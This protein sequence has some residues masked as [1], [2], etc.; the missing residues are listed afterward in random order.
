MNGGTG[1]LI[2]VE[3]M[4]SNFIAFLNNS[5]IEFL[6]QG[7]YGMAFRATLIPEA[8]SP[9]K[10]L[11]VEQY[12]APV[13]SI[14]IKLSV[15]GYKNSLNLMGYDLISP[16]EIDEFANEVNIQ[17]DIFLKTMETM[18]PLCPAIVFSKAFEG[19]TTILDSLVSKQ[20]RLQDLKMI[21]KY[22]T[23]YTII[24]MELMESYVTA[25]KYIQEYN[26][27]GQELLV[28]MTAFI[29]IE[30][31]LR[32]GYT[33]ADFHNQN[34]MINPSD[35]TMFSGL[36][37]S[38]ILIDFGLARKLSQKEMTRL[39]E[40]TKKN[41]FENAMNWICKYPSS[42]GSMPNEYYPICFLKDKSRR[43]SN[44]GDVTIT[45]AT[46][47]YINNLRI[48]QL[49]EQYEEQTDNRVQRFNATH[50][51][52]MLLP[53]SNAMK[54]RMYPGIEINEKMNEN[55]SD[56]EQKINEPRKY[57]NESS[58]YE[59]PFTN[60]EGEGEGEKEKSGSFD[61]VFGGKR[62]NKKR[63]RTKKR[64]TK[65]KRRQIKRTKRRRRR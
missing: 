31:A 23:G 60:E 61:S 58:P 9:Y 7:T 14:I 38:I 5:T 18:K 4:E 25:H 36:G 26:K 59:F 49:K 45:P 40:Y 48:A 27:R 21:R 33:H 20:P 46:F 13:T 17:T 52:E 47:H 11:D 63:K 19:D 28:N 29:L 53:L 50:S 42:I 35:P 2:D 57:P 6:S 24:G 32:T 54:N 15:L 55:E 16:I 10:K 51:A 30:L 43:D 12:G 1:V 34:V 39:K 8:S 65:K 64:L 44:T 22:A 62:K 37:M 41:D 3:N 56:E